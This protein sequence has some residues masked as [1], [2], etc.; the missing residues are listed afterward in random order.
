MTETVAAPSGYEY[1]VVHLPA[2]SVKTRESEWGELLN[3]V[4]AHGWRLVQVTPGN[5][6]SAVAYFERPRRA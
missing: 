2:S 5:G 6:L 3:R 1:T 4:A